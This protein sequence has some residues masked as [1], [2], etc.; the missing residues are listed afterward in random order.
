MQKPLYGRT[1]LLDSGRGGAPVT[2]PRLL[3]SSPP[4]QQ[5]Q[6]QQPAPALRW[7]PS[8]LTAPQAVVAHCVAGRPLDGS[9]VALLRLGS[10]AALL[11]PALRLE[12]ADAAALNRQLLQWH[13]AA[14]RGPAATAA[15]SPATLAV[16]Q[17]PP[18]LGWF[19]PAYK[20]AVV[21]DGKMISAVDG[22][23]QRSVTLLGKDRQLAEV[24]LD[25]P[26][27]SGQHAVLEV[28]F[29]LPASAEEDLVA[30][31]TSE[32]KALESTTTFIGGGL[33]RDETRLLPLFEWLWQRL[34]LMQ[35]EEWEL[36]HGVG[37]DDEAEEDGQGA[38]PED[39][40]YYV[41]GAASFWSLELML[42][43]LGSTNG[44]AVNGDR[45]PPFAPM[46]LIEGD[47]ILF[48]ASSRQYVVM[49]ATAPGGSS[50]KAKR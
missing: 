40:V 1:G 33:L 15:A 17:T 14:K 38:G 9:I 2:R 30:A 44:T 45:L 39:G 25:H 23:S 48:G 5:Q 12:R 8:L 6:L 19:L 10:M 27:C 26:S 21:K 37:G 24:P 43:D 11:R 41:N 18:D 4:P 36:V 16:L 34:L 50:G 29:A 42:T 47:V 49:R 46:A 32:L 35:R 7:C 28:A 22:V 31:L 3:T 20:L 13:R